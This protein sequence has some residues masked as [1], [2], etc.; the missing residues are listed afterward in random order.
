M[1]FLG[2]SWSVVL[3]FQIFAVLLILALFKGPPKR[4]NLIFLLVCIFFGL[5]CPYLVS[6]SDVKAD[7]SDI[8]WIMFP[9]I[10]L[11]NYLILTYCEECGRKS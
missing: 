8:A 5:A 9:T 6:I 1:N 2:I 10:M 4:K 7:A 11:A 3:L